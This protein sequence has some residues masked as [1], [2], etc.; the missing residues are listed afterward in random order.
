MNFM[1][2]TR[3][4]QNYNLQIYNFSFSSLKFDLIVILSLDF[5]VRFVLFSFC[6]ENISRD[7][8]EP[9]VARMKRALEQC[10][11]PLCYSAPPIL[12]LC[13]PKLGIFS[14]S[15]TVFVIELWLLHNKMP[16]NVFLRD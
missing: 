14:Y 2:C 8:F 5:F 3:S 15:P 4:I 12:L 6:T 10:F 13:L 1:M 11:R 9:R 16:L 7:C